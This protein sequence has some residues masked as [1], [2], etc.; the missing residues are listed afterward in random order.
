MLDQI[1]FLNNASSLQLSAMNA[2]VQSERDKPWMPGFTSAEFGK[3]CSRPNAAGILE[4]VKQSCYGYRS[5]QTFLASRHILGS[6]TPA[7]VL[8]S[9]HMCS[10]LLGL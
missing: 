4:F 9:W 3:R 5:F 2:E 7:D 6:M 1:A 8:S 10:E